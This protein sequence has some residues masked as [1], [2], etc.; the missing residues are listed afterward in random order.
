[1]QGSTGILLQAGEGSKQADGAH[2]AQQGVGRPAQAEQGVGQKG[3]A[4]AERA[5]EDLAGAEASDV[6]TALHT[7]QV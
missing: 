4:C 7:V 3:S 6:H 5:S 1:M 2:Q